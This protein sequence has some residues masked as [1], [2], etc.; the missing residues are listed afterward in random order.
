MGQHL[1][2]FQKIG[3]WTVPEF[4]EMLFRSQTEIQKVGWGAVYL[5]NHDYPR[6]LDKYIPKE[7]HGYTSATM[8]A[9]LYFL[10]RGTP[11][12]IRDRRSA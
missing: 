4:R 12:S 9:T 11:L 2:G 5:E 10:L 1:E 7:D 6:S 8:L 3:E